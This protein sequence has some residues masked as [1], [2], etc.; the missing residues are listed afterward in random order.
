MKVTIMLKKY[1]L[2]MVAAL[3]LMPL[4]AI[5]GTPHA[6]L[7]VITNSDG[8][9]PAVQDITFSAFI[10][11]RTGETQTQ[12]SSG[13]G[14]IT[15]A[16]QLYWQ[17]EAGNFA[18]AWTAG[19]TLQV[20]VANS[21]NGEVATST[22]VLTTAGSD[23][24][25]IALVPKLITVAAASNNQTATVG[26]A[27]ANAPSVTLSTG[28]TA[29][30]GVDV[31]FTA[32]AGATFATGSTN[33][34][35]VITDTSGV[36]T[37][38]A[39]TL[40]T[41]AGAQDVV[42]S[43]AG[44]QDQTISLTALADVATAAD[45]TII[46]LSATTTADNAVISTVTFKDQFNNTTTDLGSVAL[47]AAGEALTGASWVV[48]NHGDG[49]ATATYTPSTVGTDG[50]LQVTLG[51]AQI[52]GN[53][54]VT[55]TPGAVV[56]ANTTPTVAPPTTTTADTPV[57]ITVQLK[58]QFGN[59]LTAGGDTLALAAAT[60]AGATFTANDNG[61][62]TYTTTYT[63]SAVGTET[64]SF[65]V[66]DVAAPG[67][68]LT[69]T[70]GASVAANAVATWSAAAITA[71]QT[72]MLTIQLRDQFNN[73]LDAGGTIVAVANNL[74]AA[75]ALSVVTDNTNGSYTATYTPST[76]GTE[77][78]TFTVG[79]AAGSA[80]ASLAVTHGAADH[81]VTTV[82]P[83]NIGSNGTSTTTATAT[84]YDAK[85]NAVDGTSSV[86]ANNA[87]AIEVVTFSA[88][89]GAAL[90]D[91]G[92]G[93]ATAAA[94]V[95]T[96][97]IT[98]V[99]DAAGGAVSIDASITGLLTPAANTVAAMTTTPFSLDL[100]N[101][102]LV[103]GDSYTF[104]LTGCTTNSAWSLGAAGVGAVG[105][106]SVVAGG[107]CSATYTAPAASGSDTLTVSDTIGGGAVSSVATITIRDAVTTDKAAAS[108]VAVGVAAQV[109]AAGGDGVY[110][111]ISSDTAVLTVDAAGA[112]TP[113]AA[114]VATVTVTDATT[115]N[116]AT[117]I[118]SVT[119]ANIEV[120]DPIAVDAA[121][122]YLDTNLNHAAPITVTGGGTNS[123]VSSDTAVATVS[124]TG[125]VTAVAAGTAT[126]TVTE[127]TY[128]TSAAPV[129]ITVSARL[130]MNDAAG[131]AL[132]TN[133][134][135]AAGDAVVIAPAGGTA[136]YSANVTGPGA[137][138]QTLTAVA[139]EFTFNVPTTGAFAGTYT[140]TLTD[141]TSALTAERTVTV[142]LKVT[143]SRLNLLE[144]DTTQTVT[145]TGGAVG[146][147]IGFVV[148]DSNGAADAGNA[149]TV[150]IANA[151]VAANTGNS[152]NEAVATI[153]PADVAANTRFTI[154]VTNS[155][156]AALATVSSKAMTIIPEVAY[157]VT[158][159]DATDGVAISGAG[160]VVM[161][162][163]PII[164]AA[165]TG[166][167]TDANGLFAPNLPD[168]PYTFGVGVA[169]YMPA[170]VQVARG[171]ATATVALDPIAAP[172]TYSGT[173]VAG[174]MLAALPADTSVIAYDV[175]GNA[176]PI[177]VTTGAFTVTVDSNLFVPVKFVA[178][179]SGAIP[180]VDTAPPAAGGTLPDLTL[181]PVTAPAVLTGATAQQVSLGSLQSTEF[182]VAAADTVSNV[183]VQMP[184]DALVN[185]G[186]YAF[187]DVAAA[188][189]T[190]ANATLTG[191]EV[192]VVDME[193]RDAVGSALGTS[194]DNT[195]INRVMVSIPLDPDALIAAGYDPA[196]PAAIEAAFA[197]GLLVIYTA[198]TAADF[199]AGTNVTTITGA[200]TYNA[201]NGSVEFYT[202][203]FSA[204]GVGTGTPATAGSLGGCVVPAAQS[205][206]SNMLM[207][208]ILGMM[209]VGM[210]AVRRAR[211]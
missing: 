29:D 205:G 127:A 68:T 143:P 191:G 73:S 135:Q 96:L 181:S 168:A 52:G 198:P 131:T 187:F 24:L 189:S 50:A 114:G 161:N 98:S 122:I 206:L 167:V 108:G 69:V 121:N 2:G 193:L 84:I 13:A 83:S 46:T 71:D 163:D 31:T 12:A 72:S 44:Y 25:N 47:A 4:A 93:T 203:H 76:S 153:T 85:G 22:V 14:L 158:V 190:S 146:D 179:G 174:G 200:V 88:T 124:A 112:V 106:Q 151:T 58:D 28:G 103:A 130:A 5:A 110:T 33:T 164:G 63:P 32:P 201:L 199:D 37:A 128:N 207:V 65:T 185:S 166:G 75:S 169:G 89:A 134:A 159:T 35:T 171:T 118:N 80:V 95:A 173:V 82:S 18:T 184:E 91:L 39:L 162:A 67:G 186:A 155:T 86:G 145:V 192:A 178:T 175:A 19:E 132:A 45:S 66:N 139:G 27:V 140:V 57:D 23:T 210:V 183:G 165:N 64:I 154:N 105:A 51:G 77:N 8:S 101:V 70:P 16:G 182:A 195:N 48:V 150:A 11:G 59:N 209:M 49:T 34:Q 157:A 55:V 41:T 38:S 117:V 115:Y 208:L 81:I 137:F 97:T 147:V 94:G 1:L 40:D 9:A 26:A 133:L 43:A 204:F 61:D 100:Q 53:Q 90:V 116:G 20:D 36:A 109:T 120:L 126:V 99:Q 138:N 197:S 74:L 160:V 194:V 107:A 142:P 211:R 60:L 113:V 148:N 10:V 141:T 180:A 149:I 15:S 21:A 176:L 188:T 136:N 156:Q 7:G 30:A 125:M 92:A 6:V 54:T 3:M 102:T 152:Q 42:V 196:D 144:S 119:T 170:R 104:S 129:T 111:Y 123:F 202:D 56:A 78:L 172:V 79:G 87:A 62:G 177:T 17:V